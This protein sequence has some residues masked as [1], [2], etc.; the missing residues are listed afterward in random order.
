[1]ALTDKQQKVIDLIKEMNV[2]EVSDL[3]KEMEEIFGVSAAAPVGV[4]AAGPAAAEPVEEKTEFDVELTEAGSQKIN[5]I[6]AIRAIM[7]ELGLKEAKDLVEA[8]PKVIA[9]A[10]KKEKADDMVSQ[11]VA[12]GAKAVA[13]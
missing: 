9:T 7:P 3:V 4:M 12:A 6:K 10:V 1:M 11:L 13:K 8:A 2:L 5:V